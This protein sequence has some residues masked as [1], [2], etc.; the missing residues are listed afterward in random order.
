MGQ[1]PGRPPARGTR[2]IRMCS[3]DA[4]KRGSTRLPLKGEQASLDGSFRRGG[5]RDPRRWAPPGQRKKEKYFT[6]THKIPAPKRLT[7]DRL[8]SKGGIAPRGTSQEWIR[9]GRV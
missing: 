4:R 5:S 9:A 6:M 3:F 7:V 8:L 2:T 1:E